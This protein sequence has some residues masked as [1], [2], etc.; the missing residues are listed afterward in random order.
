M[1]TRLWQSSSLLQATSHGK[2]RQY[3]AAWPARRRRH[4]HVY[5]W[6]LRLA[7]SA[8]RC[9]TRTCCVCFAGLMS[10]KAASCSPACAQVLQSVYTSHNWL[11][12][13]GGPIAHSVPMQRPRLQQLYLLGHGIR[14][15]VCCCVSMYQTH[16]GQSCSLLLC[17]RC[18]G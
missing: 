8:I 14:A 4:A 1:R 15:I 9:N 5:S 13:D 12:T 16:C 11:Y 2:Q 7:G 3:W 6:L 10:V 18:Q 17:A